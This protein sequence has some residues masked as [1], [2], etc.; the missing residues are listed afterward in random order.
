MGHPIF[1]SLVARD[2]AGQEG[3]CFGWLSSRQSPMG[4]GRHAA[5]RGPGR[6][7]AFADIERCEGQSDHAEGPGTHSPP[8]YRRLRRNY[9]RH[10]GRQRTLARLCTRRSHRDLSARP[11]TTIAVRPMTARPSPTQERKEYFRRRCWR[12][13]VQYLNNI[14]EQDHRAITRR[15]NAK[16][17]F[18]EFEAARRTIQ[19]YEGMHMIRK[20]QA[21]WVSAQLLCATLPGGAPVPQKK[22]RYNAW[23]QN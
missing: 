2:N 19:R 17:G 22:G 11:V 4:P 10:S 9:S 16:Q 18:R 6:D 5:C 14:L 12:R 15:V 8:R 20:G 23:D 3:Q 1:H 13:P 21:R 7:R